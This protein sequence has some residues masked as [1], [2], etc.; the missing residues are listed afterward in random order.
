[1]LN[2]QAEATPSVATATRAPIST[3]QATQ[4]IATPTATEP[5]PYTPAIPG[6][7][8]SQCIA[9]A[10]RDPSKLIG[11]WMRWYGPGEKTRYELLYFRDDHVV[12]AWL[13]GGI[14]G[15]G[16]IEPWIEDGTYTHTN[17]RHIELTIPS[18]AYASLDY[19]VCNDLLAVYN[20][21]DPSVGVYGY[22]RIP[23]MC[24]EFGDAYADRCF[25]RL[26]L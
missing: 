19:G 5:P 3:S 16:N 6:I 21:L 14:E 25:F 10:A 22:V 24:W 20:A 1:L 13:G 4:P 2:G 12:S 7:T 23:E 9:T 11:L 8:L 26:D 17:D 15:I 18:T